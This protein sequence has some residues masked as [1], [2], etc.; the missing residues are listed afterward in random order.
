[1]QL[2]RSILWGMIPE[3]CY[4]TFYLI[5][6]KNINNRKKKLILSIFISVAYFICIFIEKYKILYYILFVTLVVLILKVL[7]KDIKL[8]DV[9]TFSIS[10]AYLTSISY[11]MSKFLNNNNYLLL[12][13]I[14][15]IVLFLPFIFKNKFHK[16]YTKYYDLW[17]GT[18][19][20]KNNNLVSLRNISVIL[21]NIV[22]ILINVVCI[23]ITNLI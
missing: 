15:R 10:V 22:I 5:Y 21:L 12:Y 2:L 23:Y 3:V 1:M 17:Y 8:I 9:F 11:I 6:T 14:G 19:K 16:L 20:E 4:F 7:Y 13:I 18:D